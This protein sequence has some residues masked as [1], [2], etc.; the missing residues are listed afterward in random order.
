MHSSGK[1]R[2]LFYQKPP[3]REPVARLSVKLVVMQKRHGQQKAWGLLGLWAAFAT[4]MPTLMWACPMNGRVAPRP[5]QVCPCAKA[6][7]TPAEALV[8]SDH[9]CCH[10]IPL[11]ESDTAGDGTKS[12]TVLA[13]AQALKVTSAKILP[14]YELFS[15]APV[16]LVQP[17]QFGPPLSVSPLPTTSPPRPF[18]PHFPS[19]TS[20]RAPP[21]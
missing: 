21:A 9:K 20:G 4:L 6:D 1:Y 13:H 5:E 19:F 12:L 16:T 17:L 8:G 14:G 3:E 10:R 15:F 2:V 18:A 7:K 11:P